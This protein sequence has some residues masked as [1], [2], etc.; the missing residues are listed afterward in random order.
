ML[1]RINRLRDYELLFIDAID[2]QRSDQRDR[3]L[4]SY[5]LWR[6]S[7]RE[8]LQWLRGRSES[9]A[10][11]QENKR[12][13]EFVRLNS[14]YATYRAYKLHQQELYELVVE[15]ESESRS[16]VVEVDEAVY[17]LSGTLDAQAK[18]WRSTLATIFALENPE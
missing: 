4:A 8:Q 1:R 3:L 14:A 6:Q 9:L 18:E 7:S 10:A 5:S 12:Q 2:D 16:T 13:S 17:R 11:R 15:L